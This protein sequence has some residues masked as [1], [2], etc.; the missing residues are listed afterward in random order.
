MRALPLAQGPD[1]D[2]M[3][4]VTWGKTLGKGNKH[5]TEMGGGEVMQE[6]AQLHSSA[7]GEVPG[8]IW[9]GTVLQKRDG[10]ELLDLPLRCPGVASVVPPT[11]HSQS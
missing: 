3:A 8:L 2:E 10:D 7:T 4:T 11:V 6:L 9:S 1:A 5:I